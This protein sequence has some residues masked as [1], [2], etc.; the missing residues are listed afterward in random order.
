MWINEITSAFYDLSWILLK[1]KTHTKS[2]LLFASFVDVVVFVYVQTFQPILNSDVTLNLAN[3]NWI[4]SN[5]FWSKFK[6]TMSRVPSTEQ[7]PKNIDFQS[8]KCNYWKTSHFYRGFFLNTTQYVLFLFRLSWPC[9]FFSDFLRAL[10]NQL[11]FVFDC[12]G[13]PIHV[14]INWV[15]FVVWK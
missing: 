1:K 3:K 9:L 4:L 13:R 14:L 15:I 5:C 6:Y 8:D 12:S 10:S 11:L 2:K 7:N